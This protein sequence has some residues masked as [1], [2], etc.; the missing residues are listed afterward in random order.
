MASYKIH[1]GPRGWEVAEEGPGG[2]VR[3]AMGVKIEGARCETIIVESRGTPRYR[4]W[5]RVTDAK[6]ERRDGLLILS[7]A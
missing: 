6:L 1:L 3:D 5:L 7:P 2:K 4:G